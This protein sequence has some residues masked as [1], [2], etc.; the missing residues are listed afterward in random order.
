MSSFIHTLLAT[1]CI[2]LAFY[3]GRF[4]SH[5]NF[6]DKFFSVMTGELI[7]HLEKDGFVKIPGFGTFRLRYKK[8]RTGRNPKTKES[9][10]ISPRYVILFKVSQQLKNRLNDQ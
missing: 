2:A 3:L 9:A 5:A 10:I 4:M 6:V 7:R 1:G 8:A